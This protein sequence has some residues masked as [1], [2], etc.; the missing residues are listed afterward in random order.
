MMGARARSR[1]TSCPRRR[2][3][4]RACALGR[5]S[6]EEDD[7]RHGRYEPVHEASNVASNGRTL[8]NS[9]VPIR[10][11][12]SIHP[13]HT[14]SPCTSLMHGA[15][16]LSLYCHVSP[17]HLLLHPPPPLILLSRRREDRRSSCSHF[18]V[19]TLRC[20][21]LWQPPHEVSHINPTPTFLCRICLS[22]SPSHIV[23]DHCRN[24]LV[25]P[26]LFTALATRE[27]CT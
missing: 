3:I 16:S 25:R 4:A 26:S 15:Q 22:I 6:D 20:I 7:D 10:I 17:I 19:H 14:L 18:R 2:P 27:Q 21:C 11:V 24:C 23:Y 9:V 13:H 12:S 1:S 8:A 5:S